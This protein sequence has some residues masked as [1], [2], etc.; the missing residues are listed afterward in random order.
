VARLESTILRGENQDLREEERE[1][2]CS[3]VIG[4]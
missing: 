2:E 1:R 4:V 3:A